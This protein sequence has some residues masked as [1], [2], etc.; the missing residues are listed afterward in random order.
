MK[1][2]FAILFVSLLSLT[3]SFAQTKAFIDKSTKAFFLTA[4]I[5]QDHKFFGYEKPDVKSKKM[6]AFSVF[7]TDVEGNPYKCPLGAYYDASGLP[8]GNKIT[9]V[10]VV[11]TFVKLNYINAKNEV[12]SIYIKRK[13]VEF[14]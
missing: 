10:S 6:I 1:T 13:F 11:G 4:N 5:R 2:L 3:S 8:E 7:T 14:M 12:T 9:F